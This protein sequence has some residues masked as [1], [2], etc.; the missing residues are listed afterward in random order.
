LLSSPLVM[1]T[2]CLVQKLRIRGIAD[3][4]KLSSAD[5][6]PARLPV[7]EV[8]ARARAVLFRGDRVE[9]SC[10]GR[11]FSL[12]LF[13]PYVSSRC[14]YCL[15]VERYRLLCRFLREETDFAS[16]KMRVLDI[17]PIW[18]FQEF[19]RS[20]ENIEYVSVDIESP[21]AMLQMDI[22]DLLF[23]DSSFDCIIC[24]HVLE[25]I[26]DDRKALSELHRVLK[27][28]GWAIIQV[29]VQLERTTDRCMM[30]KKEQGEILRWPDHLRAYG[31]DYPGILASAGF[32]VEVHPYVRKFSDGEI[33]R[34]GLDASEDIHVCTK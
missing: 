14:P 29:P 24:Y 21:L 22:K 13:S 16:G 6:G 15:S 2:S 12:F 26:D 28:D 3:R 4:I 17:G 8:L 30:T 25:H 34:Y 20:L 19:C 10:C 5:G 32:N 23:K 31:R 18:C 11:T 33:K 1:I 27:P 9:C 7:R